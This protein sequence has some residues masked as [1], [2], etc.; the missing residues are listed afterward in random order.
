[1]DTS[2]RLNLRADLTH[3]DIVMSELDFGLTSNSHI[4]S[5]LNSKDSD[6]IKPACMGLI[7]DVLLGYYS[8]FLGIKIN[9]ENGQYTST[10]KCIILVNFNRITINRERLIA[11]YDPCHFGTKMTD[12]ADSIISRGKSIIKFYCGPPRSYEP[13]GAWF[14]QKVSFSIPSNGDWPSYLYRV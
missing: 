13:S 1:M 11:W 10:E 12:T 14:G 2:E 9:I 8:T 4:L 7:L 3:S 6:C 5:G